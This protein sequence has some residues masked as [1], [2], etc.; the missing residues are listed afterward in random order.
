[1]RVMGRS[2]SRAASSVAV[3]LVIAC[4]VSACGGSSSGAGST[5]SGTTGTSTAFGAK[6]RKAGIRL[7]RPVIIAGYEHGGA[8]P[9][10]AKEVANCV[11][12]I[13]AKHGITSLLELQDP[14]TA[15]LV[16]T[17]TVACKKELGI[18]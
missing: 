13:L 7:L 4:T 11:V 16:R 2:V 1:M 12:Q 8:P 3:M 17:S 15:T 10:Q 9:A 5:R 18:K 14:S 6:Y